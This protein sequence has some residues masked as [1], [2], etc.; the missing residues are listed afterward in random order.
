[1]I[2]LVDFE[3]THQSGFEGYQYLDDKDTLVVYYSDENSGLSR[4]MVDDLKSRNVNVKMVKLL[5]QHSNALDMYIAS[6]TG[7]YLESGEK[8]CI[9]SKDKG[10]A[11]VRDFWHSLRGAEI[12]LGETIEECFLNSVQ[13]D[14]E[15]IR[16]VKERHQKVQLTQAF[17]TMNKVPTRPTLSRYNRRRSNF[18]TN[19]NLE[20]IALLPDPLAKRNEEAEAKQE[21][22][23]GYIEAAREVGARGNASLAGNP[24]GSSLKAEE[25]KQEKKA[26]RK[27]ERDAKQRAEQ[28]EDKTELNKSFREE[29]QTG[30]RDAVK[31][32]ERSMENLKTIDT[33]EETKKQN[34]SL[35]EKLSREVQQKKSAIS[36]VY[37][38]VSRTMKLVG[39]PEE[40]EEEKSKIEEIQERVAEL[41]KTTSEDAAESI[42]EEE[43]VD[44]VN[45]VIE[46]SESAEEEKP[47][48]R[49]RRRRRRKP[50]GERSGESGNTETEA[51]EGEVNAEANTDVE[52]NANVASDSNAGNSEVGSA[53]EVNAAEASAESDGRNT[54]KPEA[55]K[56]NTKKAEAEKAEAVENM[57]EPNQVLSEN[58]AESEDSTAPVEASKEAAAQELPGGDEKS[59]EAEKKPTRRRRGRKP[60]NEL[61]PEM[62]AESGAESTE[63]SEDAGKA[64]NKSEKPEMKSQKEN[65]EGAEVKPEDSTG[66]TEKKSARRGR[67]KK[68]EV[69]VETKEK[70]TKAKKSEQKAKE[71]TV[72]AS[73]KEEKPAAK[74]TTRRR[75]GRRPKET[76]EA[77]TESKG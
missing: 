9:V 67:T 62:K 45:A 8:I 33:K 5:K 3:N 44:S 43:A 50:A 37:D 54:E 14:D 52:F 15:R 26:E 36:Y 75:S 10:Y 2:V 73:Q 66:S 59:G 31:A 25:P 70:D 16:S 24:V 30:F 13:N 19:R 38:P 46:A 28:R 51:V 61:K 53:V 32:E 48:H 41:F 69:S 7:M 27:P 39:A 42:S 72:E 22:A 64:E 23:A 76:K 12:L 6:T 74:K 71:E 77:A 47:A 58:V 49:K 4:G 63:K 57:A 35:E 18:D 21:N 68:T 17:E 1:M 29:R 20:P 60:K 55:D 56:R 40:A 11:A 34:L 65:A